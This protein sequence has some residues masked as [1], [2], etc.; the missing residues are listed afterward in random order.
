MKKNK[1]HHLSICLTCDTCGDSCN[2]YP[3]R[4]PYLVNNKRQQIV[5]TNIEMTLSD[6]NGKCKKDCM[7]DFNLITYLKKH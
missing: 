4:I 7:T 2:F 6:C 5:K 3:K 1:R